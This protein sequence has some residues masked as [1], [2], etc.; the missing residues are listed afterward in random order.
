METLEQVIKNLKI[1]G[2]ND[3]SKYPFGKLTGGMEIKIVVSKDGSYEATYKAVESTIYDKFP[4]YSRTLINRV[5]RRLD[6]LD[7]FFVFYM[8]GGNLP[9][10]N[11]Y[12]YT[13]GQKQYLESTVIPKIG[14]LLDKYPDCS[15]EKTDPGFEANTLESWDYV[16]FRKLMGVYRPSGFDRLISCNMFFVKALEG[17][18][19][20]K[21]KYTPNEV[22]KIMRLTKEEYDKLVEGIEVKEA[23]K[24]FKSNLNIKMGRIY[25]RF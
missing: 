7:R 9:H 11:P 6:I 13:D 18:Y 3:I 22:M 17:G 5:I 15:R 10:P 12:E 2:G 24:D 25:R 4:T 19:L 21:K 14:E 1:K 23:D 8:Y 20:N 16:L